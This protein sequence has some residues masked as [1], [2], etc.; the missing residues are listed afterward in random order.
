MFF[1]W[2]QLSSGT[3]PVGAIPAGYFLAQAIAA[4]L[5][6][7][8]WGE[9]L[10]AGNPQYSP[11]TGAI[12]FWNGA[13][14]AWQEALGISPPDFATAWLPNG[15][16]PGVGYVARVHTQWKFGLDGMTYD[17]IY[18]TLTGCTPGSCTPTF[19]GPVG[20]GLGLRTTSSGFQ[21]V[22]MGVSDYDGSPIEATLSSGYN[23]LWTF[24]GI[25]SADFAEVGTLDRSITFSPIPSATVQPGINA[26]IQ[27]PVRIPY[28]PNVS[29][30]PI[31]VP[32]IVPE[33][34]RFPSTPVPVIVDP[35]APEADR[36]LI[37]PVW[38]LPD[39]IQVGTGDPADRV[40]I[41]AQ[42]TGT[43]TGTGEDQD[44]RIPPVTTNCPDEPGGDCCD[45]DAIRQIVIEELDNKFPPA[46]PTALLN[47]TFGLADS[48]ST[49]LPQYAKYL[50]MT[51]IG[52]LPANKGQ[53][54]G[55]VGKDVSYCGWY[56]FGFED[57][58]PGD[59][60]PINYQTLSVAVPEGARYF[61][62]TA[63]YNCLVTATVYYL[64]EV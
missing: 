8:S 43:T 40:G 45:C 14:E 3:P 52:E 26:P 50:T 6:A 9:L 57:G 59:R 24:V 38:I 49:N 1:T 12:R 53:S 39:G 17:D 15:S 44:R 23:N 64:V 25:V 56:S 5:A 11:V 22:K 13:T 51:V 20:G 16:R 63:T 19:Y 41:P 36:D 61:T 42:G 27:L 37:P 48:I 10:A 60:V 55:S 54:G 21:A 58:K 47:N 32:L 2:S 28:L 34:F 46:R 18:D 7:V 4:A 62:C 30:V 31:D 35:T 33:P 29:P